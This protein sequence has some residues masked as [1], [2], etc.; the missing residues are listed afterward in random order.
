M[1][2]GMLFR[3]IRVEIRGDVLAVR[4]P[5]TNK[6]IRLRDI[7]D[8]SLKENVEIGH[9][10]E[11]TNGGSRCSGRFRNSE[12]GPYDLAYNTSSASAVVVRYGEGDTVVFNR[13]SLSETESLYREII[14]SI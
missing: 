2:A 5:F 3:G 12:F 1:R 4:S 9:M 6:N 11:G 8:V 14:G 13:P 7:N 10:I